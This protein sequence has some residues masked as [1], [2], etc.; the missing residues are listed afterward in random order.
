MCVIYKLAPTSILKQCKTFLVYGNSS[1]LVKV[2]GVENL[3]SLDRAYG[4]DATPTFV[5]TLSQRPHA[6]EI[7]SNLSLVLRH[8]S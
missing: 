4:I 7:L 2:K 1:S 5:S 6:F 3:P 8:R